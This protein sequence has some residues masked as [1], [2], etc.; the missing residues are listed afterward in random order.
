MKRPDKEKVIAELTDQFKNSDA[1]IVTEYRGL[2]VSQVNDLRDKLGS[3]TS[4]TV[5]KNTLARIAAHE[6]GIDGLDLEIKGPSALVFIKGDYVA[7]ARVLRD[8]AKG[9]KNLIVKGGYVEGAVLS[10][11]D[12]VKIADMQTRTDAL[13]ELAGAM[14]GTIAKVATIVA[15]LPTKVVRTVDALREKQEKAA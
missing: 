6:A 14:K 10:A 7:A 3:D 12:V 4:Y 8:F 11:V 5:A 15:A 1:V 2:S 13:S 9:N